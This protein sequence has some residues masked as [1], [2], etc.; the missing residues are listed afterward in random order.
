MACVAAITVLDCMTIAEAMPMQMSSAAIVQTGVK[1]ELLGRVTSVI[2]MVSIASV[3]V[4]DMIFGVLNDVT[5]VW[6][7]ILVGA[8][9]IGLASIAYRKIVRTNQTN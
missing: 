2:K 5:V 6:F 3:A 9:G 8:A 7:P 4:G 1:K